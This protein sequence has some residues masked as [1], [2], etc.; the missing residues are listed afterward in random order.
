MR[1]RRRGRKL[2]RNPKSSAGLAAQPGQRSVPHRAR[3]RIRREQAQGQGPHRHHDL[4]GQGS[5]AARGEVHH[6]RLP[7]PGGRRGGRR[8]RHQCRSRQ[9]RLEV[10]AQERTLE[11]VE[12]GHRAGRRRPPPLPAAAWATSRRS[13]CCSTKWR[14]RFADRPGGY[15]RILRLAKPR[16]GDAGTRAMLEFV[17]VRDR[18][19]ERSVRPTF[20]GEASPPSQPKRKKRSCQ[21][22][23]V[24]ALHSAPAESAAGELAAALRPARLASSSA[25]QLALTAGADSPTLRGPF[26]R[27]GIALFWL[28]AIDV[29]H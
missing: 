12:R 21:P 17:G 29:G 4:Q 19:V 28:A 1:H 26:H 3:R 2:G 16:L 11:Q 20:E 7:R 8:I 22:R 13:A 10:V 25:P 9:R 27:A 6:D 14:P 5:P 24:A 18:V 23:E 15:T